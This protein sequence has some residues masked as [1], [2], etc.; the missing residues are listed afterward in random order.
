[1]GDGLQ[2]RDFVNVKDIV[3]ANILAMD[4]EEAVGQILNV[5]SGNSTLCFPNSPVPQRAYREKGP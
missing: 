5:A 2:T 3:Q 4:S 1:M